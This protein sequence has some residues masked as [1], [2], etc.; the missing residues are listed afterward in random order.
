MRKH[1]RY[2]ELEAG[3]QLRERIRDDL[4]PPSFFGSADQR[5]RWLRNHVYTRLP[6]FA[7]AG[8][9]FAYRYV[10]QQGF[11]DGVEGLAFH[12]LQAFWLQF[13]VDTYSSTR[14]CGGSDGT[15]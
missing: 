9:Y 11:R 10:L 15:E 12:F 14:R 3:E 13:L 1:V 7:R 8:G 5:V 4:N 6:R 2:A